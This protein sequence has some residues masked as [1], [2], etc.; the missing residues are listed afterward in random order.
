MKPMCHY[1]RKQFSEY[2]ALLFSPPVGKK[3]VKWH[4][5]KACYKILKPGGKMIRWL[6]KTFPQLKVPLL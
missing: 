3:V 5:C 2:G 1:C 6:S 4:V